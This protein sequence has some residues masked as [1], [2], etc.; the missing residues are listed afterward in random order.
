MTALVEPTTLEERI[1]RLSAQVEFLV[2]QAT[3]AELRRQSFS[4]LTTDLAPIASQAMESVGRRLEDADVTSEDLGD[5]LMALAASLPALQ[6][7]LDQLRAVSEFA[8]DA[9]Q[10]AEPALEMVTERLA[11]LEQRGY[12]DFVRSGAGIVDR[13][14][15][16]YTEDDVTAGLARVLTMLKSVGDDGSEDDLNQERSI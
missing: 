11:E 13:I 7:G 2:E 4:D 1:D 3:H 6:A 9:S 16:T 8:G 10:L 12:F 15:T 5:L 14:V